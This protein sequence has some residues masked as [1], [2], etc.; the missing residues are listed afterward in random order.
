MKNIPL[1]EVEAA[2]AV[3]LG[4][5]LARAVE[6]SQNAFLPAPTLS[7]LAAG[8]AFD[9]LDG[10]P[11]ADLIEDT[12]R[13]LRGRI[14]GYDDPQYLDECCPAPADPMPV[15]DLAGEELSDVLYW[16]QEYVRAR[17]AVLDAVA[18]ARAL[19]RLLAG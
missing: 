1:L 14:V 18:G 15:C 7:R 2:K 5:L 11:V 4:R 13:E 17:A 12:I 16:A 19:E 10:Q 6:R 9:E 8:D 3:R